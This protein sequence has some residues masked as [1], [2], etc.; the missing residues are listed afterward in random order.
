MRTLGQTVVLAVLVSTATIEMSG[1]T[2]VFGIAGAA[3]AGKPV[4]NDA[5]GLPSWSS[6]L[7]LRRPDTR[8]HARY[9]GAED[10][11]SS[12]YYLRLGASREAQLA[13]SAITIRIPGRDEPLSVSMVGEENERQL[14]FRGFGGFGRLYMVFDGPDGGK[15]EIGVERIRYVRFDDGATATGMDYRRLALAGNLPSCTMLLLD[16][17]GGKLEI[18]ADQVVFVRKAGVSIGG[19]LTGLMAGA[20]VDCLMVLFLLP[21]PVTF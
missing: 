17:K 13:D 20:L 9:L 2:F 1:C 10:R 14:T 21:D 7:V 8:I 19:L 15:Q 11:F 3:S 12:E 18:P 6:V 16:G 5:E 4:M